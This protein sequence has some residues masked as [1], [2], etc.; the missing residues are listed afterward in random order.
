MSSG[1]RKLSYDPTKCSPGRSCLYI[2]T[3]NERTLE[4]VKTLPVDTIVFDLENMVVPD[5]NNE[6]RF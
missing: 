6:G 3:S 5:F 1:M 4:K 2:S